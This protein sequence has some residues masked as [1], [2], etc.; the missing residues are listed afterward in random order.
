MIFSPPAHPLARFCDG[1]TDQDHTIHPST[2][3]TAHR[4]LEYKNGV[5]APMRKQQL[6]AAR[7]NYQ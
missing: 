6:A 3:F 5:R 7:I 2:A 4:R 1:D